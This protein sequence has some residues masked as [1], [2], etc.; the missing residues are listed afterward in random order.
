MTESLVFVPVAEFDRVRNLNA[1]AVERATLFA[2]MCR[3]NTLSMIAY[4]GSG[5]I[6]SSFSSLDIVTWLFL[7]EL[8]PQP[9][10]TNGSGD[11]YF[12]SKG[13]DG[14]GLYAAMI[15][16]GQLP[17]DGLKKLR[18]L[19]GLP[20]HPDV[21]TPHMITNTGSLGMGISKAKGM[22]F[23]DRLLGRKRRIFVMTGDGE[24]QEGQIWESLS[25]A[26]NHRLGEITVVVDHNKLQSDVR[27]SDTSDLGDLEAKFAAFGWHVSRCDG[28]D[29]SALSAAFDKSRDIVDRPKVIVAD[30]VKGRGVSFM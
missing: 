8:Q 7:H 3:L 4:A 14:P 17:P 25:S 11:L 1:S 23:A 20:G 16:C 29:L 2:D 15:A 13:H 24:L 10:K 18:R 9:G 21:G 5:H 26:A 22:V 27:V 6:G 28:H 30:T 12:S 19:G